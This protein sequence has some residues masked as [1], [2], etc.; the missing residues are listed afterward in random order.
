ME[1]AA[2]GTFTNENFNL[3]KTGFCSTRIEL[4]SADFIFLRKNNKDISCRS[5]FSGLS[6]TY[7]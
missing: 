7:Q 6:N 1:V 5:K 3:P 4:A 2:L